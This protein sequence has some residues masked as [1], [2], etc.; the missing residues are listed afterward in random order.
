MSQKTQ[1]KALP[2]QPRLHTDREQAW[3]LVEDIQWRPLQ[4]FLPQFRTATEL[5][6]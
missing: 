1:M 4:V 3:P 5:Q 6:A 2:N